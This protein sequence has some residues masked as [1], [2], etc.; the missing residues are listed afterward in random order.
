ML[1]INK[2]HEQALLTTPKCDITL[3]ILC[4]LISIQSNS[5]YLHMKRYK[6]FMLSGRK[7]KSLAL[8][9]FEFSSWSRFCEKREQPSLWLCLV[10]F[11]RVANFLLLEENCILVFPILGE[12]NSIR[13]TK[14]PIIYF[15]PIFPHSSFSVH[16]LKWS[17]NSFLDAHKSH[18]SNFFACSAKPEVAMPSLKVSNSPAFLA[19]P[20]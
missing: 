16:I 20:S 6:Q 9:T 18:L 19:V 13:S 5:L 2:V 11:Y 15:I 3:Q 4:N 7:E 17:W 14:F 12:G 8:T 1:F 10:T